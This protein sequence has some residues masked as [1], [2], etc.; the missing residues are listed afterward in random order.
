MGN[1]FKE[2]K[3]TI[4]E[5]PMTEEIVEGEGVI[6]KVVSHHGQYNGKTVYRCMV[7]FAG[8][9]RHFDRKVLA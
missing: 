5:D 4:Y 9:S 8:D 3:V 7:K 6:K 2:D 1:L